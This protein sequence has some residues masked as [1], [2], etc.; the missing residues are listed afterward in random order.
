MEGGVVRQRWK[1][2]VVNGKPQILNNVISY[3]I[4]IN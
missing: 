4:F 2:G 3:V 1:E